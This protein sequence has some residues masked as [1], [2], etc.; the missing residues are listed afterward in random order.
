[1]LLDEKNCTAYL[2]KEGQAIDLGGIA[3][4]Y[5]ADEVKRILMQYKVNNALIN[6]GGNIITIGTNQEIA[7][8]R[9]GIQNPLAARGQYI[10]TLLSTNQTIV[11]SG[12]NEQ[13]FIKDGVRYHHILSPHTGYPVNNGLLSVTAICECSTDADA[14][15]TALFVS[16][17]KDANSLLMNLNAQAIFVMEN[18]DVF[19][20]E[21]LK[22]TFERSF[23]NEEI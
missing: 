22:S 21:G 1:L 12:S 11:T 8:W 15:T 7:P 16:N 14:L 3:K 23:R 9:I 5:A 4:G 20:T 6:L 19:M 17:I 18:S 10:G 13:F 2:K